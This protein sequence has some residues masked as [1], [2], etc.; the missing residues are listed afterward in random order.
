MRDIFL[1]FVLS[2][3]TATLFAQ[4]PLSWRSKEYH[5][6][7]DGNEL[8]ASCQ[9][10]ERN[11]TVSAGNQFMVKPGAKLLDAGTCFGYIVGIVDSIPAREGFDPG[12]DVRGSQCIDVVL[13]YLRDHPELRHLPAYALT[14]EAL[15]EAFPQRSNPK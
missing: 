8:Y 12:P 1:L 14:R 11:V 4:T 6:L 9:E 13:K 15:T 2:L 7:L 3:S 5:S 10:W